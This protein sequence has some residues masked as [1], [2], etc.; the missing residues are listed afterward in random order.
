LESLI[1]CSGE[2]GRKE[3]FS[4]DFPDF[5]EVSEKAIL[6]IEIAINT[7]PRKCLNY[8][9][10]IESYNERCGALLY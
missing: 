6:A 8:K 10:P 9:T 4:L 7:R 1:A 2:I 3:A 5:G